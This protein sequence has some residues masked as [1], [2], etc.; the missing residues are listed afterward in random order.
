M[1]NIFKHHPNAVGETYFQHFFKACSF[2]IKLILMAVRAFVH[3]IFP[4]CFEHTTS[5]EI[6]EL[7]DVLQNRKNSINSDKN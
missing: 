7:N 3:A 5:D 4:W 2:G 1:K 6:S